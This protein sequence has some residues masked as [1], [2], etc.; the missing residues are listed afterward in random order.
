[1]IERPKFFYLASKFKDIRM[2][3][4]SLINIGHFNYCYE[5]LPRRFQSCVNTVKRCRWR[6]KWICTCRKLMPVVVWDVWFEYIFRNIEI[7]FFSRS[8]RFADSRRDDILL[9]FRTPG[10]IAGQVPFLILISFFRLNSFA[11]VHRKWIS[12]SGTLLAEGWSA[13]ENGCPGKDGL[14]RAYFRDVGRERRPRHV[15]VLRAERVRN[16]SRNCGITLRG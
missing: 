7:W 9:R 13:I 5:Y 3:D 2:S 12:A 4:R 10:E 6:G 11:D 14:Q 16:G 15:P 1:M 8:S